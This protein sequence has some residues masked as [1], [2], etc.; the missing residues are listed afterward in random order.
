MRHKG[1]TLLEST[2]MLTVI[3]S[4]IREGIP[5]LQ[6][7]WL[8]LQSVQ[9][10]E[11]LVLDGLYSR[12]RD[13]SKYADSLGFGNRFVHLPLL[14]QTNVAKLIDYTPRNNG[15]LLA[16]SERVLY[17]D[18][19]E[20]FEPRMI[21]TA[22]ANQ[23]DNHY[24]FPHCLAEEALDRENA[25]VDITREGSGLTQY[26]DDLKDRALSPSLDGP[27]EATNVWNHC[28][29]PREQLL[30]EFN[31]FDE[32][33]TA[34]YAWDDNEL[35]IRLSKSGVEFYR[36]F[37]VIYHIDH[38]KNERAIGTPWPCCLPK[39]IDLERINE[40]DYR[41]LL[42]QPP[43][44]IRFYS[45]HGYDWFRC[46]QCGFAGPQNGL[47][48]L[49]Q[50]RNDRMKKSAIGWADGTLGRNLAALADDLSG[51]SWAD[52]LNIVAE[53]YLNPRYFC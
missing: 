14:E 7:Y 52:R 43:R 3:L 12:R 39:G 42:G 26:P 35:G 9:D 34:A 4:T 49:D 15:C 36:H 17:V 31:G 45:E 30:Y 19:F 48:F 33:A 23:G 1:V 20:Y 8:S 46:G 47:N 24:F 21:E 11:I 29:L 22:V 5:E 44:G 28:T 50:R 40:I 32:A 37:G 27:C 13:L 18:D 16:R 38:P 41:E 53:S 25:R 6:L 51:R 2:T 10:F